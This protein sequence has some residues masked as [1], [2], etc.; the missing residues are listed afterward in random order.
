MPSNII[1]KSEALTTDT[2]HIYV[3][4]CHFVEPTLVIQKCECVTKMRYFQ[5]A[6]IVGESKL[7]KNMVNNMQ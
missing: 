7:K 1:Q 5:Y 6:S 2:R 4:C 3:M